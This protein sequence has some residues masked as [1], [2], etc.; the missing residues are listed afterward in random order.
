MKGLTARM[1]AI[2]KAKVS[3]LL[4]RA[5]HPGETL[6][7]SYQRQL[8]HLQSVKKGIAGVITAKKRLQMQA[9]TLEQQVGRL[10]AQARQALSRERQDLTRAALEQKALGTRELES[11]G[12]HIDELEQQQTQLVESEKRLRQRLEAFRA[13]KEV[14]KAQYAAAEAQVRIGEAATGV[15]DEMA[16]VGAA[17]QRAEDKTA[18][19]R[20]RAAA[21]EELEAA[22][23]LAD[24]TDLEPRSEV[25]REL[26]RLDLDESIEAELEQMKAALLAAPEPV[27]ELGQ[28]PR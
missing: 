14:V 9:Q 10:D 3:K 19:L 1:A 22:G 13:R 11:L 21:V 12:A 26:A 8:E 4:D 15:S 28:G 2:I 25:E 6:D 17:I 16:D 20:A 23:T 7:Y 24:L 27:R 18:T 5:E